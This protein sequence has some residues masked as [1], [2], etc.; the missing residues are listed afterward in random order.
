M[1]RGCGVLC[2][3]LASSALARS[4]S[5]DP[6]PPPKQAQAVRV[7]NGSLHLDGR[8]D[9]AMWAS[10]PAITDFVQK[11]PVYGVP[12]SEAMEIRF[13]Y[14]DEALWVGARMEVKGREI[15]APLTRRDG[16]FK[17][18]H[19]WISL[20][21]FHDRRTAYSYGVSASGARMDFLH[22]SDSE[23]NR[24]S[25][26]D[27][28]WEA[29]AHQNADGWTA[30]FRIPFSQLRFN[31][32][33]AQV[34][35]L[36][37]DR[38]IPSKNED[39]FWIPIP[40]D[41]TGWSS[42]MGELHGIRDIKPTRRVELLPYA[43]A[44][45]VRGEDEGTPFRDGWDQSSRIGLDF[46]MGLGPNLTLES[47][48]HPDFGQV[49][50]D[51]A[52]VNLSAFE[53]FFPEKRPFFTEG[54]AIFNAVS[55][56]FYSRRI[57]GAPIGEVEGDAVQ[58]PRTSEILAA[59]KLSGRSASGL[60]M[61]GLFALTAQEEARIFD[62][63]TER[64][65]SVPVGPRTSYAVVRLRQELGRNGSGVGVF[66]SGVG[67]N[68][69]KG[70]P[71]AAIYN[72]SAFTAAVDFS[73]RFSRR[74]YELSGNLGYTRVTGDP[75]DIERLQ[76]SSARY[77]QRPDAKHVR[78]DPT[79]T[80]LDGGSGSLG[81]SKGEGRWTF[82]VRGGFESPE[83]ERNDVGSLA[84]AD[85]VMGFAELGYRQTRPG[86]FYAWEAGLFASAEKNYAGELQSQRAGS[87]L[88]LT[89]RNYW[90]SF[91]S[92]NVQGRAQDE[93]L[94]R[95]GP[96]MGTPRGWDFRIT[97]GNAFQSPTRFSVSA[98][99]SGNE[100]GGSGFSFSGS[101]ALQPSPRF[102]L[103]LGP[104]YS[105]ATTVRQYVDTLSWGRAVTYGERYVFAAVEQDT[106]VMTLRGS[107]I[108]KPDLTLDLYAEPFAASGDYR[109]YGE[110]LAPGSRE[111]RRYGGGETSVTVNPDGSQTIREGADSFVIP[112]NDF[113][114][115]SF[116]SNVVLRWEY[117]PGSTF[118]AVWQQDRS[119]SAAYARAG[120]SDLI[121]SRSARGDN[122]FAL[123]ASFFW[124]GR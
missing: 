88:S 24:D 41:E 47:T 10:I 84:T 85:G 110:L 20:D 105:R 118:Y 27:P 14:D 64:V 119:D 89:W 52:E 72:R 51:P 117:R 92:L 86:F 23:W 9:E 74:T 75:A 36:N 96:L 115:R 32:A 93:R 21:T 44:T 1:K 66:L 30:E 73:H 82:E 26:Y 45:G 80:K 18:E 87:N 101:V 31:A 116:R 81:L 121:E 63:A 17:S 100:D 122:I 69:S 50:A 33:E 68:L 70:D 40:K 4:E 77:F 97:Q 111:L 123:K 67:R 76:R 54:A 5:N 102:S 12:P 37:A 53:T 78:L 11:E 108:L 13:A 98:S 124:G 95:G 34:W 60:T 16:T 28:V 71:L 42:R 48:I 38:W 6:T 94:T 22:R 8:P 46:K 65:R 55:G 112:Q 99:A 29:K 104:R 103:S 7:P 90:T 113:R 39:V 114:V 79:R 19:L 106:L 107:L 2:V 61:G 25:G 56:Y 35:G 83:H 3:W 43:A 58:Y 120:F 57:G 15:Q 59:A 62:P 91:L 109:D 49:E